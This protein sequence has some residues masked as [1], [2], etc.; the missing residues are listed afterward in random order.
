MGPLT[1]FKVIEFSG[2]GPGPFAGMM[3]ADMGAEVICISRPDDKSETKF[4]VSER[5]KKSIILDLKSAVGIKAS[6][7]LIADADALIEGFR[8]GVMERLGLGPEPC[9]ALNPRLVYGRMTG[10]GQHGP[11]SS[12]AGHDINYLALSGAL[13]G[14]GRRGDKP[15]LP[16]NYLGDFGGGAMYLA[17][18][19]TCALLEATRSGKGQV[20]DAAIVDGA[21]SLTACTYGLHAEGVWRDERGNNFLDGAAH[22]YDVYETADQQFITIGALEPKFY[23]ELMVLMGLDADEI[24]SFHCRYFEGG[25]ED[26]DAWPQLKA[27]LESA[28]KTKT[29]DEWCR[30]LEGTDVCF[31]P[32]LS[33]REAS[34]HPHNKARKNFVEID[35]VKQP[36]PAPRFSRTGCD[37]PGA[38]QPRGAQT[39]TVLS[40]LALTEREIHSLLKTANIES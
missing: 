22:F 13:H 31:A 9:L 7:A 3:L 4:Q 26:R 36:A 29:R 21:A 28:F 10:W 2:I 35:N 15:V 23:K 32:V 11:L 17:F 20:V 39:T 19:I 33:M 1:G 12:S 8:P 34:S 40:E 6:K 16:V 24:A 25:V 18:G 14:I 5:G 30:L 38:P 27:T 37:L